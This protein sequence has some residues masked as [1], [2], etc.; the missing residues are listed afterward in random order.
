M[1]DI[2]RDPSA[3][4]APLLCVIFVGGFVVSVILFL[5]DVDHD[6]K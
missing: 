4:I 5:S 6:R 2:I 1:P 3:Y